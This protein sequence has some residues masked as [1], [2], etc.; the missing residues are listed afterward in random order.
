[1]FAYDIQVEP[2]TG[3]TT[4]TH[5]RVRELTDRAALLVYIHDPHGKESVLLEG[6]NPNADDPLA[7][8][9]RAGQE[10]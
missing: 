8:V 1:M 9:F 3:K 4:P 5:V 6:V 7:K 2:E 10:I